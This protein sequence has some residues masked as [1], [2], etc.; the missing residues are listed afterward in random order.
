MTD[1][2]AV[3]SSR[4]SRDFQLWTAE[5]M[6]RDFDLPEVKTPGYLEHLARTRLQEP[7][8]ITAGYNKNG[9]RHH[10]TLQ[11]RRPKI[12]PGHSVILSGVLEEIQQLR[13]LAEQYV[14][15][16]EE[17]LDE[18]FDPQIKKQLVSTIND[19]CAERYNGQH[20]VIN[21]NQFGR[22]TNRTFLSRTP[23]YWRSYIVALM[24]QSQHLTGFDSW[25]P[26][27]K[28][29]HKLNEPTNADKYLYEI[30]SRDNSDPDKHQ[31]LELMNSGYRGYVAISRI[32]H[33]SDMLKTYK[34]VS[35]LATTTGIDMPQ[36]WQVFQGTTTQFTAIKQAL[37]TGTHNGLDGYITFANE[38]CKGDMAKTFLNVSAVANMTGL[39]MPQHWQQ[40]IGTTAQ[41]IDIKYALQTGTHNGLDGYITFANE[42]CKGD[43]AK[44][45]LNVSAVANMTGLDMPEGWQQFIGTTTNAQSIIDK[46]RNH[47]LVPTSTNTQKKNLSAITNMLNGISSQR[48]HD[49]AIR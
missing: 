46:I 31:L 16:D 48:A 27:V 17:K 9:Q 19:Y 32:F 44:T 14:N 6:G 28:F 47:E 38:H 30:F 7:E 10:K 41:F 43:M 24:R 23:E 13:N 18:K 26:S 4:V 1:S 21:G 3:L 33:R 15:G 36:H 8:P 34:N 49:R 25:K 45:F 39:D 5:L 35:A 2:V 40:F 29:S 12:H 22:N 37:Q 42:H 11:A 20:V